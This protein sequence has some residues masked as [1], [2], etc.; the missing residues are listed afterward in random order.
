M[1]VEQVEVLVDG[2][3]GT[4]CPFNYS[5]AN[6]ICI[7]LGHA[8]VSANL[9]LSSPTYNN[10]LLKAFMCKLTR[11][12]PLNGIQLLT[13]LLFIFPRKQLNLPSFKTE[14]KDVIVLPHRPGC[15]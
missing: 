7:H 14:A 15:K 8:Y 4:L 3:F 1:N 5:E 11:S 13:E 2:E 12:K 9:S 6:V 10:D